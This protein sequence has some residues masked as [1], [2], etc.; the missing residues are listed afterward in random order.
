MKCRS[1]IA[2][3]ALAFLFATNDTSKV[4]GKFIV[5]GTDA[6]LKYVRAAAVTLEKNKQ[7]YAVLLSSMPAK[8][9]ILAWR[10]KEP[11]EAG[12]SFIVL[13]LESNGAVWVAEIGHLS[14]KSGRFGVVTE[15]R[16]VSF[17]VKNGRA[18]G[19]YTTGG[20]QFFTRDHYD[21]DVSFDAPLEK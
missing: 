18:S 8:G 13:M 4:S 16:K 21:I 19:H 7:G 9:D 12:G 14:S 2:L 5:G 10:T 20:D 3:F 15:L 11:K 6:K 1:R 17:E